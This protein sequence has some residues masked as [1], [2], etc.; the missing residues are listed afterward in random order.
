MWLKAIQTIH[1][2]TLRREQLER[3]CALGL[4]DGDD[5]DGFDEIII[6]VKVTWW[7]LHNAAL[8]KFWLSLENLN[9][10]NTQK[11]YLKSCSFIYTNFRDHEDAEF[12]YTKMLQREWKLCYVVH[13]IYIEISPG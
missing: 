5:R 8:L 6:M 2:L 9:T 12:I 7:W 11:S 1:T 3:V 13:N 10:S 4:Y